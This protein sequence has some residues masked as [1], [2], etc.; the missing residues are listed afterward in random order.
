M[1]KLFSVFKRLWAFL[2]HVSQA[3]SGRTRDKVFNYAT[4]CE[5]SGEIRQ[6]TENS[7]QLSAVSL[8]RLAIWHSDINHDVRAVTR[9]TTR[10]APT[11]ATTAHNGLRIFRPFSWAMQGKGQGNRGRLGVAKT[12]THGWRDAVASTSLLRRAQHRQRKHFDRLSVN[13]AARRD[14]SADGW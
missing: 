10:V 6:C 3:S 11:N 13:N 12:L 14:E 8:N 2:G 9:A 7:Y 5:K 4:Q 1:G